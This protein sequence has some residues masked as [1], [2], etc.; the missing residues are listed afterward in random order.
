MAQVSRYH[1]STS[2]GGRSENTPKH[3]GAASM[4]TTDNKHQGLSQQRGHDSSG[5]VEVSSGFSPNKPPGLD[6]TTS[7][8]WSPHVFPTPA[9]SRESIFSEGWDR[10]KCWPAMPLSS[11]ASP[12]SLS[13]TVS[14]CSSVRSGVFSPAVVQIRKHALAPAS[15]LV[16]IPPSCFSSCDSLASSIYL[17]SPPLRRRPPL[18]R[19]SLLTAILRK[20]RL[21]VLSASLPRPYTPCW[22]VN[23][24]TLTFCNACSAAS[25]V[26]SIPLEF[27]SLFASSPT[28]DSQTFP[29]REPIRS[30]TA[31]PPELPNEHSRT[32]APV[33]RCSRESRP[34]SLPKWEQAILSESI[35][36]PR[37]PSPGLCS[38]LNQIPQRPPFAFKP[39]E[40]K[41]SFAHLYLR[42]QR[43]H[44]FD[45][46]MT[47]PT[48]LRQAAASPTEKSLQPNSSLSKLRRLSERLRSPSPSSLLSSQSHSCSAS[49]AASPLPSFT[50]GRC[51]SP[52]GFPKAHNPTS[53]D[54]PVAFSGWHSPISSPTPTPS[55]ATLFRDLTPSPSFSLRFT[56][57]PRPGS[58]ISDCSD[59]ESKKRKV[60]TPF[61]TCTT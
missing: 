47:P 49:T 22:P 48:L 61:A 10:D 45:K 14:P 51:K 5:R 57:S 30:V 35:V 2:F 12:S 50:T 55:P 60:A 4:E 13:R 42:S 26:A 59:R 29:H 58:G 17:Q 32:H 36:L 28:F 54:A 9:S 37:D 7:P 21:P 1:N 34:R 20:G 39:P 8:T 23:P 56:P 44:N 24:V 41:P 11:V 53:R 43:D 33:K 52:Q 31:P 6:G 25:S 18:T 38:K 15:S 40:L 27:S 19:L 46:E 16:H 3:S